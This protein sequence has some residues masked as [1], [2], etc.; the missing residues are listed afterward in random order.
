MIIHDFRM[1]LYFRSIKENVLASSLLI[2]KMVAARPESISVFQAEKRMNAQQNG[3]KS[4]LSLFVG[5]EGTLA[6]CKLV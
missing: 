5:K 1:L 6:N 2:A 4:H 3:S